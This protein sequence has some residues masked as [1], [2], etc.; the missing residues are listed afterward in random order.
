MNY[1]SLMG[2]PL[3]RCVKDTQIYQYNKVSGL[4]NYIDP[5]TKLFCVYIDNSP[6]MDYFYN[7]RGEANVAANEFTSLRNNERKNGFAGTLF[8]Q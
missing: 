3:A 7:E 8:K 4:S 6:K 1:D 2:A 5:F